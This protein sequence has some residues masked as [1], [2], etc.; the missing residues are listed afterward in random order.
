MSRIIN[1][2]GDSNSGKT[3]IIE[4]LI[5][6]AR[7]ESL[8]VSVVKSTPQGF[9]IDKE[10]K[11]SFRFTKSGSEEVCLISEEKSIIFIN[12]KIGLKYYILDF[13]YNKDLIIIEGFKD[14]NPF[15]KIITAKNSRDL[16]SPFHSDTI[17]LYS[18]HSSIKEIEGMPIYSNED[19]D[20][21]W[22]LIKDIEEYKLSLKIND[23]EIDINSFV[24]T[25][26][27]MIILSLIKPLRLKTDTI[28][29]INIRWVKDYNKNNNE[30]KLKLSV[31]DKNIPMNKYVSALIEN[32]L[33]G[34]I[35]TI[36]LPD[37][38]QDFEII[39]MEI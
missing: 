24:N 26:I 3:G 32:V 34:A 28:E 27:Q 8:S 25:S 37:D 39:D 15:K 16:K 36:K 31:N 23:N 10:G 30:K 20:N 1:I 14:I 2:I 33:F 18:E 7:K 21:L 11:D 35:N 5:K 9:D 38:I 12:R 13:L 6:L 29:K 19:I 4:E 17:A 22:N